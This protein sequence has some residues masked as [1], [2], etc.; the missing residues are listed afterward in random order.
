LTYKLLPVKPNTAKAVEACKRI[1]RHHHPE[2]DEIPISF[3]KII[4]ELCKWYQKD[5]DVG[6]R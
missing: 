2:F 5:E 4:A 1:F 6:E 3:N